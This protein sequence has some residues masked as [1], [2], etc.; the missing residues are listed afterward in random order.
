MLLF[1]KS[2]RDQLLENGRKQQPVKGTA[3]EID[4]HP[5]VKLFF[6][7]SAATWLLTE[8]HPD[9]PDSAFG[10]CD[11]GVGFPELGYVS[12]SEIESI[13]VGGLK[14]ERDLYFKPTMPLSQYAAL[15]QQHGRI[16]AS[17]LGGDRGR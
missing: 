12:I 17:A 4:F 5:V 13:Q 11:L 10:L 6:P 14:I 8:L 16:I 1:T 15:A 2:I 3:K 7:A 9:D